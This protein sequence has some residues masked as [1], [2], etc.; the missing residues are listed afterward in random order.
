VRN[1]LLNRPI[2]FHETY[3][4]YA[5]YHRPRPDSMPKEITRALRRISEQRERRL[6]IDEKGSPV[7]RTNP[8]ARVMPTP[9]AVRAMLEAREAFTAH[10]REQTDTSPLWNRAYENMRRLAVVLAVGIAAMGEESLNEVVLDESTMLAAARIVHRSTARLAAW[11]GEELE[12]SP[13]E[14]VRKRLLRAVERNADPAGWA[15]HH[16][17]VQAVKNGRST[18]H[19]MVMAELKGLL[20]DGRL[21]T[22]QGTKGAVPSCYR[23]PRSPTHDGPQGKTDVVPGASPEGD[24][25]GPEESIR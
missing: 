24:P 20:S 5:D 11:A 25:S 8:I 18:P 6:D 23:R 9:G 1:G 15:P 22:R 16:L 13:E 3:A 21:V 4:E 19:A 14:G 12:E 7:A 17:V 2:H 10:E